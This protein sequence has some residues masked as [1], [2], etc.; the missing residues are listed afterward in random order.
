MNFYSKVNHNGAKPWLN[1]SPNAATD[2]WNGRNQWL[3][4]WNIGVNDD[5]M[6]KVDYVRVYAY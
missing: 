5:R 1:T 4:S 2:F 6:M 3:S